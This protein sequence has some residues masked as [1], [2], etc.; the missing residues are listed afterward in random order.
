[1]MM[2]HVRVQIVLVVV[3]ITRCC[4]GQCDEGMYYYQ[5]RGE[6]VR[7]PVY[8]HLVPVLEGCGKRG[9]HRSLSLSL[10]TH[11]HTNT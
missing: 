1:M 8:E 4:Y 11:T 3:I 2:V 6:C 10:S 5:D 7:S 9:V